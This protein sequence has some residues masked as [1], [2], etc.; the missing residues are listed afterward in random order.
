M[1]LSLGKSSH[2]TAVRFD[3]LLQLGLQWLA[4]M[5]IRETYLGRLYRRLNVNYHTKLIVHC[6][7][8]RNAKDKAN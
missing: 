8:M 6:F 3:L 5:S 1:P 7:I 4:F 2:T